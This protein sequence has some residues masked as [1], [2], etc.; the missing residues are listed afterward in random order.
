MN[1][2][3]DFETRS[4]VNIRTRG[5]DVYTRDCEAI[6]MAWAVGDEP[7][8]LWE[9][10]TERMPARLRDLLCDDAVLLIAHNVPFDKAV[11]E[12]ALG[13][14]TPIERWHDTAAQARSLG[15]PAD[16]ATLSRVL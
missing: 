16:L 14:P 5:G 10:Q 6:L 4:R 9:C 8:Q 3:L 15:L 7:V 11:L 13:L 12:H 1:L 2:Y